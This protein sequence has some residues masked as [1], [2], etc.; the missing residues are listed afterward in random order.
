M[1]CDDPAHD[2]RPHNKDLW[3]VSPLRA[4]ARSKI[5]IYPCEKQCGYCNTTF[6]DYRELLRHVQDVCIQRKLSPADRGK[7]TVG[8][9]PG[10]PSKGWDRTSP[11]P[12]YGAVG[13]PEGVEGPDSKESFET[14]FRNAQLAEAAREVPLFHQQTP[15]NAIP[16]RMHSQLN[17]FPDQHDSHHLTQV[18]PAL[19]HA[20]YEEA[21]LISHPG[22]ANLFAHQP[23]PDMEEPRPSFH[24][25]AN[26]PQ[27]S[28]TYRLPSRYYLESLSIYAALPSC[29][30]GFRHGPIP[31]NYRPG[32]RPPSPP[33][34]PDLAN[35][36]PHTHN[37][38][39]RA[40][41]RPNPPTT[42]S[43]VPSFEPPTPISAR[44]TKGNKRKAEEMQPPGESEM[45]ELLERH[46]A[47][48]REHQ[49]GMHRMLARHGMEYAAQLNKDRLEME[50]W[51]VQ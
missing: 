32:V 7:V 43:T 49:E 46:S 38:T 4:R 40:F 5:S 11:L 27:T 36:E 48:L 22:M 29:L 44:K 45:K 39:T 34:S 50:R 47:E 31:P 15:Q 28:E 41:S 18:D 14:R 6:E 13:L 16:A 10:R 17:S 19:H 20:A 21:T 26:D 3:P 51:F 1:P 25:H 9:G 8:R 12:P 23:P 24:P 33:P 37:A 30:N 2:G 42:P 35:G